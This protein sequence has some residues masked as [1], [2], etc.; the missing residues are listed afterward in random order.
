MLWLSSHSG[1]QTDVRFH[2]LFLLELKDLMYF[3]TFETKFHVELQGKVLNGVTFR[4]QRLYKLPRG[5]TSF[6]CLILLTH[7]ILGQ[8]IA[9]N[10][11]LR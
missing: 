5:N 10:Y 4:E 11:I 8:Y 1:V 3:G 7:L 6:S 2:P 9:M